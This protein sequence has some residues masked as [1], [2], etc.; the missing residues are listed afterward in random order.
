MTAE[1][2]NATSKR[3]LA[4]AWHVMW[5]VVGPSSTRNERILEASDDWR[6]KYRSR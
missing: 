4:S 6:H 1:P 5:S 3:R 2:R